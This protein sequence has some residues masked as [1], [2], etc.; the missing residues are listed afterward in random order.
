MDQPFTAAQEARI[1]ELMAAQEARIKE[2]I[3]CSLA[4]YIAKKGK[5]AKS[6]LMT[7]ATVVASVTVILGGL[8]IVLGWF[9]FTYIGK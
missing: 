5:T 8:K 1:K 9:G 7:T 6:L 4:A 3:H 2:L